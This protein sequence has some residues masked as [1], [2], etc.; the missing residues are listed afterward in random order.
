MHATR[1]RALT[2]SSC[3]RRLDFLQS[4][5]HIH[6]AGVFAHRLCDLR[7]REW[8]RASEQPMP[9]FR[10]DPFTQGDPQRWVYFYDRS[11]SGHAHE[12]TKATP[13]D[14]ARAAKFGVPVAHASLMHHVG[15]MGMVIGFDG[16]ILGHQRPAAAR[17]RAALELVL[18]ALAKPVDVWSELSVAERQTYTRAAEDIV[19]ELL[20]TAQT[21]VAKK[22]EDW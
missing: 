8:V 10:C 9:T 15:E 18:E 4:F 6:G 22:R 17:R 12:H 21:F 7:F 14:E 16:A 2:I 11:S 1:L 19:D 3:A 5:F 20:Q 13:A